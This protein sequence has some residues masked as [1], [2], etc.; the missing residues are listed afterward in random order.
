MPGLRLILVLLAVAFAAACGSS[1]SDGNEGGSITTEATTADVSAQLEGLS[2]DTRTQRLVELAQAEGQVSLYTSYSSDLA[3]QLT[4]G[5]GDAYGIDVSVYRAEPE[6]IV[7]R[8]LEEQRAGFEGADVV[9]NGGLEMLAARRENLL[10]PYEPPAAS[11]L[12]DGA[13]QDGWTSDSVN[14]FVLSWNTDVV[15]EEELPTS[16]EQLADPKWKGNLALDGGDVEWYKTLR[17][18]WIS[19]GMSE[20]KADDLLVRIASNAFVVKGHSAAAALQAAGEFGLFVNFLHI[21]ERFERDGASLDWQPAVQPVV[22]KTDGV[23]VAEG[24]TH[25]AAAMRFVDWLLTNGQELL[26]ES[27]VATRKDLVAPALAT[28]LYVDLEDIADNQ[29]EWLSRYDELLSNGTA[30]DTSS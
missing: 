12:I 4:S 1:S 30:I 18:H 10:D 25:P 14:T 19:E 27:N 17:D 5:F 11:S 24:T 28:T 29:D 6:V 22:T 9:E 20:Q 26:A 7:Q 8:L 13:R 21:V 2:G 16:W 3:D 15:A 23:G